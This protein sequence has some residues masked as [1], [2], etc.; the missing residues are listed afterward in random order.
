MNSQ[1]SEQCKRDLAT[2]E[3]SVGRLAALV[4]RRGGLAFADLGGV[5]GIEGI[6]TH[7][8]VIKNCTHSERFSAYQLSTEHSLTTSLER[9]GIKLLIRGRADLIASSSLNTIIIEIKSYRDASLLPKYGNPLHWAQV[10][11]YGA[12][13]AMQSDDLHSKK[14]LKLIYADVDSDESTE[15]TEILSN[16][17]LIQFLEDTVAIYLSRINQIVHWQDRRNESI[18]LAKFPYSFLRPGQTE[19]M[20]ESL[21]CLRDTSVLFVEAPT[22]IGKT[23]AVLYSALKALASSYVK[24]IFYATAMTSTRQAAVVALRDLREANCLVRSLV[25]SPKEKICL[26]PD[27][28]CDQT[29]CPYAI[30]YYERLPEA[31]PEL[32]AMEELDGEGIC[33]I[34]EKYQLCPFELSLDYAYYCDVIIGDYNHVFDPRISLQRFFDEETEAPIALLIDE[35]HNL[36]SRSRMMYSAEFSSDDIKLLLKLWHPSPDY[37]KSFEG[38]YQNLYQQIL[39]IRSSVLEID[40]LFKRQSLKAP[41]GVE[42]WENPLSENSRPEDW[43]LLDRFIGLRGKAEKLINKIGKFIFLMQQF[44]KEERSFPKRQEFLQAFFNLLYFHRVAERYFASNYFTAIRRERKRLALYQVCLDAS[45]FLTEFYFDKHPIIFFSATL[46]PNSYYTNILD[47]ERQNEPPSFLSLPS[48]FPKENRLV[49]ID[50]EL[51]LKFS[52]RKAGLARVLKTIYAAC[53]Q[54]TGNYLVFCPSFSY[55]NE[56]KKYIQFYERPNNLRFV[57]QEAGMNERQKAYF[58]SRFEEYGEES[59][60]GLAVLGSLFNEGIDLKGERLSGVI[61]IGVGLPGISPER[62][63]MSQFYS[64]S[65]GNGFLYA[66]VFPGFNRVQQAIGRL[67]RSEEDKGFVLLIDKRW[68]SQPYSQL[69][70]PEWQAKFVSSPQEVAEYC[71]EFWHNFKN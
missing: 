17:E 60:I 65:I 54:K 11:L 1:N 2:L 23:M 62:E 26:Q 19:M 10:K 36:A 21:A 18:L 32:L 30:D 4:H 71:K 29:L 61:V 51:S 57:C 14:E 55:L 63:L 45:K 12:L 66:Y 43:I 68:E 3:I 28:Y 47:S 56:L 41:Q 53:A 38:R 22:G 44:L 27:L 25:L 6:Q 31:F 69:I 7:Q 9:Q 15:F 48:P 33:I 46:S 49:L 8:K 59:L 58:L 16:V 20:R 35:A 5:E 70:P 40:Q 37:P 34:A 39:D 42:N 50:N 13:L 24:R 52:E 67:I 64:E